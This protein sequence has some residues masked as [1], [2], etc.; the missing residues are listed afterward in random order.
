[1]D[2][3]D[4]RRRRWVPS[5]PRWLPRRDSLP[6]LP[7]WLPRRDSLPSRPGWLPRRDRLPSPPA[8]LRRLGR[9]AL[10]V[11]IAVVGGTIGVMAFGDTPAEVGP[12]DA[13]FSARPSLAGGTEVHLAPLGRITLDSHRGP[14]GLDL[15][16]DEL[17]A[18]E[19]RAIAED[20]TLL[21]G[22]EA[23]LDDEVRS[24]VQRLALRIVVT[25]T[26]G[27]AVLSGLRRFRPRE[28]LIGGLV[29]LL[30]TVGS[31]G[32][33]AR[34]WRSESLAEPRYSGVL[35]LAPTAVGD[36]RD[37]LDR[38]D[39]YSAQLAGLVENVAV[40]YQAGDSIRSFQRDSSTV[41]VLHVSDL[42]LNP[43]AFTLIERVVAQFAVDVVVDTGDINDWGTELEGRFVELI[44]DVGAP[45]LY[46]RGNH[47]SLATQRA[48]GRQ[49]N[50]FV[51]D[52]STVTVGG[53]R[54]WGIGDPRF[55]P[56]KERAGSGE[57][58][59]EVADAFA[60]DTAAG[61]RDSAGVQRVDVALVHDPRT[62]AELGGLVPLVLAGHTHRRAVDDLGDGTLLRVEGSTGGAGLRSLQRDEPVPLQASI[63]YFDRTDGTLRAVD[64]ITVAGV[65]QSDVRIEREVVAPP[66]EDAD[67]DDP[68]ADDEGPDPD[69]GDATTTTEG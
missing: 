63:L 46:V 56:D 24:A 9:I 27:G 37:V 38:L 54:F 39:D 33:A 26:V 19:A 4:D 35:A 13:T 55:T 6:S 49:E 50:A 23:E 48:V 69:D 7:G 1:M 29:A 18:D 25:A 8:W 53:L 44:E 5:L 41:A 52:D 62:A 3:A 30:A 2:D 67:G 32:V 58:Q 11:A 43:Q 16:V 20:P 61:L 34:T 51:L 36:A 28:V 59:Q 42:H 45:Y 65:A 47:D 31:M 40:L 22:L 68:Q 15:R 14:L 57:D 64:G 60:D 17:Q 21:E 66:D 10:T 12:F